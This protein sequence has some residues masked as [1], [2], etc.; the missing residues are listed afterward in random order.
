MVNTR[1]NKI[2]R[3]VPPPHASTHRP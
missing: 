3:R 1:S 2:S